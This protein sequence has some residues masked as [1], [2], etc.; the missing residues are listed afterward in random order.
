MSGSVHSH[1]VLAIVVVSSGAGASVGLS[2]D[3][4]L[5][6]FERVLLGF[7]RGIGVVEVG[8]MAAND[9]TDVRHFDLS[10]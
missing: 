9:V 8:L 2:T 3:L 10:G 4:L 7:L 5:D 1:G 6:D